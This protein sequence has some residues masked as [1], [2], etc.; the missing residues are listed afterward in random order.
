MSKYFDT[1]FIGPI[2][3]MDCHPVHDVPQEEPI[4]GE[5]PVKRKKK[6]VKHV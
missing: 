5:V 6:G 3:S 1:L 2:K 4:L